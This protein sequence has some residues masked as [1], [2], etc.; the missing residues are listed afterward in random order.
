METLDGLCLDRHVQNYFLFRECFK[1]AEVL[2]L[3]QEE[4]LGDRSKECSR[5]S[6]TSRDKHVKKEETHLVAGGEEERTESSDDS[7]CDL[8][9]LEMDWRAK[10][11]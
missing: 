3:K 2:R 1:K 4:L 9:D 10:H 11:S 5:E 8:D 7:A 6:S